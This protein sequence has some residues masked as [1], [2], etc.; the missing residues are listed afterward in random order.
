MDRYCKAVCGAS[1]EKKTMTSCTVVVV[2]VEER[3]QIDVV[4]TVVV[5]V[6]GRDAIGSCIGLSSSETAPTENGD[7]PLLQHIS[8]QAP[9]WH[10]KRPLERYIDCYVWSPSWSKSW[11]F[12]SDR[13]QSQEGR[14]QSIKNKEECVRVRSSRN[15]LSESSTRLDSSLISFLL[16]SWSND[17]NACLETV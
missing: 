16:C 11:F 1:A 13:R 5:D 15:K 10:P 7:T 4:A 3:R 9:C 14:D 12:V 17:N 6:V 8:M 2:V